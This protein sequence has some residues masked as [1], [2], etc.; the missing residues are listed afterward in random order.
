M[1]DVYVLVSDEKTGDHFEIEVGC[2]SPLDVFNHPF[3]Y[4]PTLRAA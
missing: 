1:N 3:A 4:A 2:R